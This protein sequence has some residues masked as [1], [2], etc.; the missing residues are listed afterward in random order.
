MSVPIAFIDQVPHTYAYTL[1]TYAIQNEKQV[2]KLHRIV[3]TLI[4]LSRK[5]SIGESTCSAKF[6][7]APINGIGRNGKRGNATLHMEASPSLSV[8][9]S[10]SQHCVQTLT[11]LALERCDTAR[12]AI[13]TMGMLA[14]KV[15]SFPSLPLLSSPPPFTL[16]IHP[17]A[18]LLRPG[19]GR[20]HSGGAGRGGGSTHRE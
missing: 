20:R 16:Y 9:L 11:E 19:L 18:R 14:E 3:Q 7:A 6:F 17:A 13:Q 2:L 12:C 5:V 15:C 4:P 1:G 10:L 8:P